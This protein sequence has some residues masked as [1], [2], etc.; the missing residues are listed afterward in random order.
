[1]LATSTRTAPPKTAG[2]YRLGILRMASPPFC[3][4]Q[5]CP[6]GAAAPEQ[7]NRISLSPHGQW[8]IRGVFALPPAAYGPRVEPLVSASKGYSPS[9]LATFDFRISVRPS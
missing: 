6:S 4:G 8:L 1:M 7:A 5:R 2:K 9:V 3:A